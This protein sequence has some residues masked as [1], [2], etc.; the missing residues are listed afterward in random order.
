M[1]NA[2]SLQ[3][4][5]STDKSKLDRSFI[6]SF[7]SN[8]YWA[9]GRTMAA[10]ETC[11]ANSLNFGVYAPSGKQIGYARVVTDYVQFAYL[12]DLFIA[13]G[14]RGNGYSKL[15]MAYILQEESLSNVRVWRLATSD[16]HALYAQFGFT[17]VQHP[18]KLMERIVS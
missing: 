11:I 16:A 18:E 9:K 15:L 2:N 8:A 14:E 1:T 10:V 13:E 3:I 7:I 6:H 17:A 5:I 4:S 12:M